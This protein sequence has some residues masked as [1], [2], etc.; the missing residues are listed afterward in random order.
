VKNMK[1]N[2]FRGAHFSFDCL[3]VSDTERCPDPGRDNRR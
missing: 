3:F 1:Q 2:V